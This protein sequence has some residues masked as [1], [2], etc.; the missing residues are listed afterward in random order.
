MDYGGNHVLRIVSDSQPAVIG[1]DRS[2]SII[3]MHHFPLCTCWLCV[4]YSNSI[5]YY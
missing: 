1:I 2:M 5:C 3:N 4:N